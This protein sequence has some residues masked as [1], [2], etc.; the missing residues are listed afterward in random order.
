MVLPKEV[1]HQRIRCQTVL[2]QADTHQI[3]RTAQDHTIT[4]SIPPTVPNKRA[5]ATPFAILAVT[6]RVPRRL[7][8]GDNRLTRAV[9]ARTNTGV[10][11]QTGVCRRHTRVGPWYPGFVSPPS[12][13]SL[14]RWKFIVSPHFSLRMSCRFDSRAQ[15]LV[16][17]WV[18][19][20]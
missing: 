6:T 15:A 17:R 11:P 2:E 4:W 13:T 20:G 5:R 14:R 8:I 19:K 7:L 10:I 16:R 3:H 18:E 9:A 1:T 12:G